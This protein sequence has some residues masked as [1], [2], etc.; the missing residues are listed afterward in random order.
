MITIE[1]EKTTINISNSDKLPLRWEKFAGV[2]YRKVTPMYPAIKMSGCTHPG[3]DNDENQQKI[4]I[5]NGTGD[6]MP[7]R[8]EN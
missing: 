3:S 7:L 1:N 6:T 2:C 5:N 8:W 4:S